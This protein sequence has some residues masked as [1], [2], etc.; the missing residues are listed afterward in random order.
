MWIEQDNALPG[1]CP[2]QRTVLGEDSLSR[3]LPR[4]AHY[5]PIGGRHLRYELGG[6]YRQLRL[7]SIALG[8]TPARFY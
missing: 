6:A 7:Y 5:H 3:R 2:K 8:G 4:F 1:D